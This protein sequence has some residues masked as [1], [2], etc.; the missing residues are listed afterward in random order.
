MRQIP[1]MAQVSVPKFQKAAVLHNDYG[2][3]Y[4]VEENWPV[5]MPLEGEALVKLEASGVCFGDLH[6]RDGGP[7]AP[8]KAVR[9]LVGGHEGIGHVAAV[10][11]DTGPIKVGDRVGLGWRRSVCNI[12][13]F[14]Q[15]NRD[16]YCLKQ[17][18]NG[19]KTDGTFQGLTFE[20]FIKQD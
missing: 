11:S 10:G 19:F 18:A 9:P 5:R 15:N 17:V 8:Q 1:R 3:R 2:G 4:V 16:N 20:P 13:V 12:C 6:A 7:P 14:C